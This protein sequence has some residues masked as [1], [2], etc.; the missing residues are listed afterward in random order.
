[1]ADRCDNEGHQ[2][3]VSTVSFPVLSRVAADDRVRTLLTYSACARL[4]RK[5][6]VE[7]E[8]EEEG[9]RAR[10]SRVWERKVGR[11][12]WLVGACA[13]ARAHESWGV[14]L[15]RRLDLAVHAVYARGVRAFFLCA[16]RRGRERF[17]DGSTR[18]RSRQ[19][20]TRVG[21]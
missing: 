5:R 1:M 21:E 12:G 19:R 15:F 9:E 10:S 17:G 4:K 7:E 13:R 16:K 8:E 14:S 2:T 6:R 20:G 3:R 18:A 11:Q